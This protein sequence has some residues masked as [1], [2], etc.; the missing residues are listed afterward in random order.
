MILKLYTQDSCSKCP[1]AKA[2]AKALENTMKVEYLDVKSPD[3]LADALENDVMSTPSIIIFN[4]KGRM[5]QTW[6][7]VTPTM[8]EVR[9]YII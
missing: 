2:L 9:R 1:P 6:H 4:D 5:I 8:E 3:G 7:G